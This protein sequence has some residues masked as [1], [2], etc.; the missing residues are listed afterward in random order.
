ME[1]PARAL[2][3]LQDGGEAG[4]FSED[5]ITKAFITLLSAEKNKDTRK[6]ILGSLAI[7]DYTIP[8]VVERTRDA[9]EDVRRVAFLAMT[10]KARSTSH[11]SPYD[12]V[13]VVNAIP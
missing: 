7:S 4:D 2:S 9:S 12:P 3:R 11:W 10:S 13:R 8:F 5:A 1:R 6:A